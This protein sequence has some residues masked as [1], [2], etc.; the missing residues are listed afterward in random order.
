MEFIKSTRSAS[1][2]Y[3]DLFS[4]RNIG[5]LIFGH[6]KSIVC[7]SHTGADT[8]TIG[9]DMA[10]ITEEKGKLYGHFE[11]DYRSANIPDP[12]KE[13]EELGCFIRMLSQE[14]TEKNKIKQPFKVDVDKFIEISRFNITFGMAE[15]MPIS[16]DSKIGVFK[17]LVKGKLIRC[18]VIPWCETPEE[19]GEMVVKCVT[20]SLKTDRFVQTMLYTQLHYSSEDKDL[21]DEGFTIYEDGTMSYKTRSGLVREVEVCEKQ[22]GILEVKIIDIK[23]NEIIE[24]YNMKYEK[25]ECESCE[26]KTIHGVNEKRIYCT[27]CGKCKE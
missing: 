27:E 17:N 1:I 20:M 9:R 19:R 23:S 16:D 2:F 14:E 7:V 24:L 6:G 8:K 13:R 10:C 21:P 12:I 5:C 26:S 11:M 25:F 3:G 4:I 22:V 15:F 18:Y